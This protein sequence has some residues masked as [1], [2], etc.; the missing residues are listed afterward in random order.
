MHNWRRIIIKFITFFMFW[1]LN[2][3]CLPKVAIVPVDLGGAV[4]WLQ[5]N[6]LLT[7]VTHPLKLIFCRLHAALVESNSIIPLMSNEMNLFV[8]ATRNTRLLKES[9]RCEIL[10][11]FGKVTLDFQK[12]IIYNELKNPTTRHFFRTSNYVFCFCCF[13]FDPK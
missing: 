11:D 8:G 2:G 5:C 9:S 13:D 4:T 1:C 6:P 7:V 3:W 10:W 12:I